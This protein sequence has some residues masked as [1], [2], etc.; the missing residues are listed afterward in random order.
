[1]KIFDIGVNRGLF[2]DKYLDMSGDNLYV[3]N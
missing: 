1:M 3:K 2:T